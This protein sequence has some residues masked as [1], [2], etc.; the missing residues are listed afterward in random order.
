MLLLFLC[1]SFQNLEWEIVST[2][3]LCRSSW[4]RS[5]EWSC[6]TCC[7]RSC[8]SGTHWRS[9]HRWECSSTWLH[10]AHGTSYGVRVDALNI[11]CTNAVEPAAIILM[12]IQ[13]ERNQKFLATL[14]VKLCDAVCTEHI[15]AKL[16]RI[17][18]V[19]FD[20]IRLS[21]PLTSCRNAASFRQNGNHL[22]L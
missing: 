15:E 1:D 16:L 13:I 19:S 6:S 12:S 7:W 20:N 2:T 17:L 9:T 3:T 8:R 21:L 5:R 4:L 11:P 14:D 22:S 10:T 18:L